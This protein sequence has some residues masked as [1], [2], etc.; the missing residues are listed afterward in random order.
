MANARPLLPELTD[1]AQYE[2]MQPDIHAWRPAMLAI[3]RRHA[4]AA[5]ALVRLSEGTNVVFAA[6]AQPIIN[7]YPP[8]WGRLFVV[9]HLVAAHL[10]GQVGIATPA[11]LPPGALAGWPHLVM[12]R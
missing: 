4:L 9:E 8:P 11:R 7:I 5:G 1:R 3:C 2:A 10:H 12:Q 6:G